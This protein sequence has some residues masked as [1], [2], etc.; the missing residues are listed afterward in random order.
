MNGARLNREAVMGEL[1]ILSPDTPAKTVLPL[2]KAA[3]I[4]LSK[5]AKAK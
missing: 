5:A 1:A 3:S 2:V 4:G